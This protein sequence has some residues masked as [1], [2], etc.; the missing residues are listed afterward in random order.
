MNPA[1]IDNLIDNLDPD[2]KA[3]I[4]GE[5]FETVL[6]IFAKDLGVTA[7][8][9]EEVDYLLMLYFIFILNKYELV[10]ALLS[11]LA[12]SVEAVSE[13]VFRLLDNVS[14]DLIANIEATYRAGITD[15]TILNQYNYLESLSRENLLLYLQNQ[16]TTATSSM[17]EHQPASHVASLYNENTGDLNISDEIAAVEQEIETL[18]GLR[19][20]KADM[21]AVQPQTEI[22]HT[23]S[24]QADILAGPPQAPGNVRSDGPRWGTEV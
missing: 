14:P 22:I 8:K 20:M 5:F 4:L 6:D 17:P 10:E 16:T 15:Q 7:D 12:L 24:S 3:L 21:R 2:Y 13:A 19:T 23:A 1:I 9:F 18:H 11:E